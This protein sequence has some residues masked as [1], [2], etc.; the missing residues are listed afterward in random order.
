MVGGLRLKIGARLS[1][2]LKERKREGKPRTDG[3]DY[4]RD[5]HGTPRA[6]LGGNRPV[7]QHPQ[8]R[9]DD[10]RMVRTGRGV[11]LKPLAQER[12][13]A[14][15]FFLLGTGLWICRWRR[16]AHGI[17]LRSPTYQGCLS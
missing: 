15:S 8:H 11:H 14:R 4:A 6:F 3:R 9:L 10:P 2:L 12:A 17:V 5:E 7:A 13:F 16:K 1:S